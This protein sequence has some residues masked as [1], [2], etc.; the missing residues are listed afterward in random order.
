MT[1][2]LVEMF[3]SDEDE[4]YVAT[5]PDLPGCCAWGKTHEDAVKEIDDAQAA[6]I[7]ACQASREAVLA[8]ST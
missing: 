5:F 6:W 4:G 7:D 3:W 1:S 8:A 2:Y